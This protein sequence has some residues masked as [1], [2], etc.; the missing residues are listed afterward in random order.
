[1]NLNNSYFSGKVDSLDLNFDLKGEGDEIEF[2]LPFKI[3]STL[4][5]K[6][7]N[8][9]QESQSDPGESFNFIE[10]FDL[11]PPPHIIV[12]APEFAPCSTNWLSRPV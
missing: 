2:R 5:A 1:M 7:L 12:R 9:T 3:I 4:K 6:S 8:M 11:E 10:N